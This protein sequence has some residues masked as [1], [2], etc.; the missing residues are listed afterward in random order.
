M[1]TQEFIYKA[2]RGETRK[3]SCG[4]VV[5]HKDIH[6]EVTVYSYGVHYPLVKI[7]NGVGFVNNTG[8]SNTTAKHIRWA[9][10][11][12]YDIVGHGNVY[13]VPL[14]K[15]GEFDRN[16]IIKSLLVELQ[17]LE[18]VMDSKKRKDTR[19]YNNLLDQYDSIY[20]TYE[21]AQEVL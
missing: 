7:I 20:N 19:V 12:V 21:K 14:T 9:F 10:D 16:S 3:D 4:S 5:A 18:K 17:R 11:A 8:Y 6:G 13:G 1:T 15:Y 2:L